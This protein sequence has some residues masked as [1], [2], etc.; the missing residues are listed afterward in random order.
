MVAYKR[1]FQPERGPSLVLV[2]SEQAEF[3]INSIHSPGP[4]NAP[5]AAG[6]GPRL[7]RLEPGPLGRP[8]NYLLDESLRK[9]SSRKMMFCNRSRRWLI[10]ATSRVKRSQQS[11]DIACAVAGGAA[12]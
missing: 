2:S 12:W 9:G 5:N 4:A 8:A 1:G 7:G 6:P 3:L 11:C 10:T